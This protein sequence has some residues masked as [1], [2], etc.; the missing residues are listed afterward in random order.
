M[1]EVVTEF[2]AAGAGSWAFL[3]L[4][5]ARSGDLGTLTLLYTFSFT[6]GAQPMGWS[7]LHSG[8]AFSSQLELFTTT[9]ANMPK[10]CTQMSTNPPKMKIK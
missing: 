6:A 10:E 3:H 2:M 9:C 7:R 8:W 1:I 4:E 5:R